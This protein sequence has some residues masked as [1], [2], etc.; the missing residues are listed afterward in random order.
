MK[1]TA[2]CAADGFR[3]ASS[4]EQWKV[5]IVGMAHAAYQFSTPRSI[6]LNIISEDTIESIVFQWGSRL[7]II[8]RRIGVS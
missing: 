7:F 3:D 4:S 5:V 1:T 2:M 8:S 6:R